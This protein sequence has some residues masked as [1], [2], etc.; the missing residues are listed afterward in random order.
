M[1][2]GTV[3]TINIIAMVISCMICILLPIILLI[4]FKKRNGWIPAFFIGCGIFIV[5]ALILEQAMHSVV[6]GTFGTALQGNVF[7]Y[8]LYGGLAAALFEEIGRLVAFKFLLKNHLDTNTALMYGAGHGGIEAILIVGLTYVNNIVISIM[9]N[10]GAIEATMSAVD[11]S[12]KQ[13]TYDQIS[14]LWTLPAS[15]FFL[16]GIERII[17]IVLQITLSILVYLAVKNRKSMFWIAAFFIHFF[18]DF[19][20]VVMANYI[21]TVAVELIL[22][23]MVVI[24]IMLTFKSYRKH[25]CNS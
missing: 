13:S 18:V 2:W 12:L 19:S 5:F 1:V 14:Q 22:A 24:V 21:P 11:N 10:S 6:L 16:G 15:T 23:I 9:I 8:A 25:S 3:S 4:L 17:A 20:T 7:L